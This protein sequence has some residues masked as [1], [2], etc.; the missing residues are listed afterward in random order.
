[1]HPFQRRPRLRRALVALAISW[2]WSAMT[3]GVRAATIPQGDVTSSL[4]PGFF[5]DDASTG[6]GDVTVTQPAVASYTRSLAG[7][8]S[9]QTGPARLT[10]TGFGFATSSAASENT[11]TTLMVTL[12]YL[13]ADEVVGGSD[14]VVIG[15]A[16][17]TY[18]FS[19]AGEYI[20]VFDTP[21]AADLMIT[22]T[23][24]RIQVAP[25]NGNNNGKV[26][27]KTGPLTYES[28]DGPK[29]SLA[30]FV[31][32]QR[33]NLAKFQP[34]TV[35]STNGQFLASY[36]TDGR[37]GTF[38][39]W[40]SVTGS[41]PHWARVD[42]P[43]PVEVGSAQVF[44]GIDDT[45]LQASFRIQ[46]LSG[47]SWLD[48]PGGVITENADV[49]R[50]IVFT[51][52]VTAPSF[53]IHS[54]DSVLRV[55]ELALYPPKGGN[56][57]PL[58]TDLILNLAHQR[59]ATSNARTTGNFALLAV[60]GRVNKD[61]MWQTSAAGANWLEIDLMMDHKIGSAHL[62]SGS[63]G[64]APLA[65]FVLK[66]WDGS[67]WQEIPGGNVTGNSAA[68]RIIPFSSPVTTGRVRLEFTN[69][70]TASVRE[71]CIFPANTSNTGYPIGISVTGGPPIT[72]KAD[73][74]TD[75]F[76]QISSPY[77]GRFIAVDGD[78]QPAL[79]TSGLA[80]AQGQYQILL[81]L[82]TGT[83]RLRNR[84]TGNCLSGSHFSKTPGQLLTDAPYSALPHQDWILDPLDGG[85]F[86]IIN[87]WSGLA[88]DVLGGG[89]AAG[90]PLVQGPPDGSASQRWTMVYSTHFPK[91][92][93]GGAGT[94]GSAFG[95]MFNANWMYS[96]GLSTSA[97]LPAGAVFHPMQWGNFNWTQSSTAASTW[98]LYPIWQ[99]NSM[100]LHLMGFNEPDAFSQS[101]NSL[102]TENTN[103]ADFSA[104][105]SML[106][107][108]ELWPRLQA[109]D[110][111]LVSP[112]PASASGSWLP[113]FYTEAANRGYRVDYTAY[114]TYP[115]P[116]GGSSNSLINNLQTAYTN[117][118]RPVWLTE[119][120]FVD[121]SRNSSWSEED[122]YNCLAEFLWRTETLPWLRKY[123]LFVFTEDASNPQPTNPWST[124]VSTGGAPRSNARDINGNL[125]AF[126]KLYA[127][128]DNDAVVRT[129]K[130][131]YIHNRATRK[132]MA[133]N[134]AQ[135]N[136]AGRNIRI[137]GK[138]VEWTLVA[139][140]SSN[141]YFIVSSLDGRRLSSD[142]NTV[143]LVSAG[144]TGTAVEWSLT[145]TTPAI[146]G[147]PD[148]WHYLGHP[149]S[150]KRLK[151]AY[152]NSTLTATF[153]MDPGSSTVDD[154]RWRFIVP[155]STLVWS[156]AVG[157]SWADAPNWI[158][159]LVPASGETI[160][161]NGSSAANLGTMLDQNFSL[162]GIRLE[163]PAGPV[164]IGG[165]QTLTLGSG[166]FDLSNATRNLTVTAPL[167]MSAE[168]I[169][170]V[171]PG[172]TLSLNGGVS[173]AFFPATVAGEGT[174][175]L[176]GPV[177]PFVP[178]TIAAGGTMRPLIYHVLANG[179]AAAAFTVHGT[180]DLNGTTQEVNAIGGSGVI[181]NTAPEP[182]HLVVGNHDVAAT[183]NTVLQDT[184]GDLR[185]IK[186]GS[187]NITLSAANTYSGG[188]TNNGSGNVVPQNSGAFGTGPVVM[189]G[190]QIYP[191]ANSFTF[192]N[193]LT[194][195]GATLRIGGGGGKTIMW[196]GPVTITGNSFIQCDGSTGGI[197][198]SGGVNIDGGTLSS[199][200]NNTTNTISAPIAGT[201]T[202]MASGFS[203]GILQLN[204]A[205][206]FSGA[207][208]AAL[209][210][211]RL[212]DAN[213]L[214]NG[215]LDMNAADSGT[216][217]L[218]NL[219]AVIGALTGSR[220][221][222]LGNG[223]ISI[224]NNQTDT[225]Y[226]GVLSG[227]GS[228]MKI[229]NGKLTLSGANSYEGTTAVH[230]GTLAMGA[231]NVLPDTALSIGNA[232]FDASTF[233]DTLG[234]LAIGGNATI[235]LGSGA[236]LAF[237]ASHGFPWSGT[238]DFTGAF[239]EGSSIRFGNT[240][241]G[242]TPAQL[243][244]IT[245]NGGG[246]PFL[247]DSTGHLIQATP[248]D[249]WKNQITNGLDA[250]DQDADGDGFTNHQ[251]FLFGTSPV[252]GNGSLVLASPGGGLT[253]RWLQR[254]G[255]ATY[256]LQQSPELATGSWTP[257]LSPLPVPDPNQDAVPA[258]YDRTMVTI[259]T[260]G[261]SLFLRIMAT[262][263]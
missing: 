196:T 164:S 159:G 202:V 255:G 54:S 69:P 238:L 109:M 93:V 188:F 23:R 15:S 82:G 257:L 65:D 46:Y 70:G 22:G 170:N 2:A 11:A 108:V 125:T 88:L 126:G 48:A 25:S 40:Q 84:A 137:D 176:G 29:L 183:L 59:P 248:Y 14:D 169:W 184:G 95:S 195:N 52:P 99:A 74:F 156:G 97:L 175:A 219:N 34:V 47:E 141:R 157:S 205:N 107:A 76:Y 144:T 124:S 111:P 222:A 203:N 123:A 233:S 68:D 178:L 208:R 10:F 136:V 172:R 55:R 263:N 92:G 229:G 135:T 200:P 201:G 60:D 3:P 143:S 62:Y 110:V 12:T 119:F 44:T 242:L 67:A 77:A 210:T 240:N 250:R 9:P 167:V 132:R 215:T 259:P 174:V 63:P 98:K 232:I 133:N 129:D 252:E 50:N 113:G 204:A 102:D 153:S 160:T 138:L 146:T 231:S 165:V 241:G 262:E 258:G 224:G 41:A 214:Q 256:L 149:A 212:G 246:G 105:R 4:G 198:L 53:R 21:L 85:A 207:Y 79:H 57:F 127:A 7:L 236:T 80:T 56:A 190:S 83:F 152:N 145:Q 225:I 249:I 227:S 197:T 140:G 211:L 112:A 89:T 45:S 177:Y 101:G 148:G 163:D 199:A 237:A 61:S 180:L 235:N 155:P 206:S 253:L 221:L 239:V 86:Q 116:G 158:P 194:L 247:L 168:Q 72:T 91:K 230:A 251:E 94:G 66:Y 130:V 19:G 36:V 27:F 115:G 261:P 223:S 38:N 51:T 179:A 128:W 245:V 131:Y 254:E 171:G 103:E 117:W 5:V 42:F 32:P 191:T 33:F 17:G 217:N 6:G 139:A 186:T 100:P 71:L 243:A 120:S 24:F 151:M 96:W 58:G 16:S 104:T 39:R 114:H 30:G 187:G 218:N 18:S 13:G 8:L 118:N 28:A 209:G 150:G 193:A 228:M 73:D 216:V 154:V 162:S 213:A 220:N 173:G 90:T 181:D 81:N 31:A 1:M 35:D 26:R 234:T 37:T 147:N 75:S 121:W 161:F 78:G 192:A 64:V 185:L 189:N 122:S 142:G 43:H 166:G 182:A 260:A 134:T 49:E 87:Q 244:Q 226:S 106:K 20:F